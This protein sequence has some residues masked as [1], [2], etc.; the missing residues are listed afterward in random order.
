MENQPKLLV[1]N[2]SPEEKAKLDGFLREIGAPTAVTIEQTQGYLPLREIIE[3]HALPGE[4][5]ET[6]E[7]VILF[8]DLPQKGVLFLIQVFKQTD[9]PRPIYAVVTEHSI[10]WPFNELLEHLIE[11]RDRMEGK[12]P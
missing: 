4:V 7:K 12:D 11:E 2:Y 1:W 6:N 3:G 8:H 5:L 9:L 10:E